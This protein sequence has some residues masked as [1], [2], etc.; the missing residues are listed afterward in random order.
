MK[1]SILIDQ[2]FLIGVKG[3]RQMV[4][5][6]DKSNYDL[7]YMALFWRENQLVTTK[8]ELK[9]ELVVLRTKV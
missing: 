5:D 9:G 3:F 2:E 1:S 6:Q 7:A 8:K 4:Q